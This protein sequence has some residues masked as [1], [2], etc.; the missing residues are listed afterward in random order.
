MP[1]PRPSPASREREVC[2][3]PCDSGGG[4]GR[5]QNIPS[6]SKSPSDCGPCH[7]GGGGIR[8]PSPPRTSSHTRPHTRRRPS[9]CAA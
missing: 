4:L 5:G 7:S 8:L 3:L 1:P 2:P 9:P 6:I